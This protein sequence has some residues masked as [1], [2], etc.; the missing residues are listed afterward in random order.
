MEEPILMPFQSEPFN[1]DTFVCD[2]FLK[3]KERFNIDT[4]IETGSCLFYTTRWLSNNFKE[5]YT[6]ECNPD[7]YLIGVEKVLDKTNVHSFLLD[8]VKFLNLT[9]PSFK[10]NNIIT[11]LDAHWM[12]NCPLLDELEELSN[13]QTK[14]PPVIVIH[15]FFTGNEE[16]GCD[17]Y[18]GQ[19]FTYEWIEPKIKNIERKLNCK[20]EYYFNKETVG[21]KR[22][23]IYLTPVL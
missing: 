16:L 1:G 15:D 21:A 5:V 19:P 18:N 7:Y 14:Q 6:V 23:V 13:L 17:E 2:E 11:F 10:D 22:G 12:N 4:A 9:L 3:L 8:S 20:Y